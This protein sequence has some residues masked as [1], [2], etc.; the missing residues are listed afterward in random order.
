MIGVNSMDIARYV[1]E[2]TH[3][4]YLQALERGIHPDLIEEALLKGEKRRY[5]K[6]GIKI[7]NKG[8]K[9]TII[10]VGQI[11]STTIKIFTIEEG[12]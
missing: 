3:H 10:C 11:I 5:A 1:I 8:A 4:A 12:N 6:H 9:R 2:I 7:I